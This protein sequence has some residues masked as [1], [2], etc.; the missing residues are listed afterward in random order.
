MGTISYSQ[1]HM[2]RGLTGRW[3]DIVPESQAEVTMLNFIMCSY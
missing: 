1:A 3:Q 2:F